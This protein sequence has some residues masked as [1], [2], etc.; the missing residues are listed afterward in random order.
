MLIYRYKPRNSSEFPKRCTVIVCWTKPL[1]L[2]RS[3]LA[4][5]RVRYT[6]IK[7]SSLL[8]GCTSI[9]GLFCKRSFLSMANTGTDDKFKEADYFKA[10]KCDCN[11]RLSFLINLWFAQFC[12]SL[13]HFRLY[14]FFLVETG[15]LSVRKRKILYG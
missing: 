13:F 10:K 2:Q 11:L 6:P 8:L 14:S 12:I 3:H 7:K 9:L 5:N 1:E 15:F 4:K